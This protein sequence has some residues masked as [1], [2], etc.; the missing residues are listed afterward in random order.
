MPA[1]GAAAAYLSGELADQPRG[2]EGAVGVAV[3][4]DPVAIDALIGFDG[5]KQGAEPGHVGAAQPGVPQ[6]DLSGDLRSHGDEAVD[7]AEGGPL[8]DVGLQGRRLRVA[9]Q[10]DDERERLPAESGRHVLDV[11]AGKPVGVELHRGGAGRPVGRRPRTAGR[12]GGGHRGCRRRGRARAGRRA[13][14]G[15]PARGQAEEAAGTRDDQGR[16]AEGSGAP[17]GCRSRKKAVGWDDWTT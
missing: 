10:V 6:G 2:H 13:R 9:V 15:A 12:G 7:V 5:G 1:T 16:Q 8:A 3:D 14:A 4:I 17:R 11:V